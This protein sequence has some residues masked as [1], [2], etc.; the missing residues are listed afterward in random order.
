MPALPSCLLEPAWDQFRAL[1]PDRAEFD[2]DHPLGCHRRR[3]PDRVVFDHVVQ[4][5]VHGSGYERISSPGCSD[6]TIRRRVKLWAQMGIS[7][8]LHRIALEAYDRM[9]GLDLDEISVDGCITKAPC[10][11][12][13]AGRS[14][15][16]RGKQG[17]KRSVASDACGVPLGIVSDGANRHDSPLLGPTLAAAKE[18]AGAMPEAVNVNLDRGYDSTK[19]RVLIGELGFSAEIARKGVPAPI[20]AGKRWVVERTHSWMNDYGKLRRCT[21]RSGD[22]VDFYLYLAAALVTLRML[23]RRS[24]SR[25]RW[26]GRPN[27]RRL[28]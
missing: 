20:Q 22:V 4:A 15:V 12:E 6:R 16:D 19:S 21:E 14:P 1:L 11:G 9:I 13:K 26:D 3:I 5:L 24:T 7:Q 18:Q 27:S 28:K 2:P 8:A 10:G 23:I 17:L 25:Y